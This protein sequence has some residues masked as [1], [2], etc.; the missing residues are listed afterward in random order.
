LLQT[1]VIYLKQMHFADDKQTILETLDIFLRIFLQS[2]DVV[3]QGVLQ[4]FLK[5]RLDGR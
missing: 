3:C 5:V 2:C 1:K 4:N